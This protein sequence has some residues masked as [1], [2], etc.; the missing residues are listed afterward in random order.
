MPDA[1][2]V[3]ELSVRDWRASLAFYRDLLGFAVSYVRE[4]EGFACLL[5]GRASL[6]IDQIGIGRDF[7]P[8]AP[9]D[10]LGLGVN[11]EI[12]VPSVEPMLARLA[13]AGHAL[14]LPA[15]D[16]WYRRDDEEVGVR[17]FV[18]ADPDGYLLRFSEPRGT[19]PAV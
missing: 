5:L 11:L 17:Q 4:E 19:R 6:M 3:P 15:E 2:L 18:V 14:H 7:A 10:R 8:I 12:G 13:A 9:G 16:R 1:A